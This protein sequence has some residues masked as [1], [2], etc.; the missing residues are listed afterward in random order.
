MLTNLNY[1]YILFPGPDAK[2]YR[3]FL[4]DNF[5]TNLCFLL[6]IAVQQPKFLFTF[7]VLLL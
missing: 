5:Y 2:L 3:S 7:P 4:P 6:V 1:D